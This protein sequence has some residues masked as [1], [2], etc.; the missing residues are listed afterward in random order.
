MSRIFDSC[1]EAQK[2][3]ERTLYEMGIK[4]RPYSYQN[5]IVK[6]DPNFETIELQGESYTIVDH[7]DMGKMKGLTLDWCKA[8]FEERINP[9]P[10]NPG[11]AWKLRRDVWEQFLVKSDFQFI[12]TEVFDYTY[13]KRM[14]YQIPIIINEL[15]ERPNTRQAVIEVH[16]NY[17][18]LDSMGGKKRIP[19][20]L[21]Y[22]FLIRKRRLD[23]Y[24]M[25]RSCDFVTHYA[26]DVWLAIK[27][28]QYI[29]KKVEVEPGHFHHYIVSLHSYLKDLK[30]KGIF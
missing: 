29:A 28:M 14:G 17:L 7:S 3:I 13:N 12:E 4:V 25:Q 30:G 1:V 19:C 20:S 6:D 21:N 15:K 18:D 27:L 5:K 23:I 26:N 22:T 2:E 16:N 8:E 10:I 24:Y 9:I 11:E